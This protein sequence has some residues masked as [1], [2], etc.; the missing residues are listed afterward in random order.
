MENLEYKLKKYHP[1]FIQLWTLHNMAAG[2]G[3]SLDV[4]IELAIKLK[5]EI[6]GLK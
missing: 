3:V 2:C 5:I 4:S 6:E 1:E